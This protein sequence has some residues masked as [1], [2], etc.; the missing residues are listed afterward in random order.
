MKLIHNISL[1]SNFDSSIDRKEVENFSCPLLKF[2]VLLGHDDQN[3]NLCS[4]LI[5]FLINPMYRNSYV[6]INGDLLNDM[7][8]KRLYCS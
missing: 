2:I 8:V 7:T 4:G 5:A 6:L 1:F 3:C